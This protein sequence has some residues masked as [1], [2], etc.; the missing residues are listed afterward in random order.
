MNRKLALLSCLLKMYTSGI[1]VTVT[2]QCRDRRLKS[3]TKSVF[4]KKGRMCMKET[5]QILGVS[6]GV[7]SSLLKGPVLSKQPPVG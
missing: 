2:E 1:A 3:K 6:G 5:F 4:S 7:P